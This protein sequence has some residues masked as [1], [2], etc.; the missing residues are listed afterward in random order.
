[1]R[2]I[3][4]SEQGEVFDIAADLG[5]AETRILD[6]LRVAQRAKEAVHLLIRGGEVD[7]VSV[8]GLR[9]S[10]DLVE[11]EAGGSVV[12]SESMGQH[13][14]GPEEGE[15]RVEH[16]DID[17]LTAGAPFACEERRG[18]GLGGGVGTRL[19]GHDISDQVGNRHLGIHLD[20]TVAREALDDRVVDP[21]LAI[22][23]IGAVARDR[24]VDEVGVERAQVRIA[25]AQAIRRAR[26][27][28]LHEDIRVADEPMGGSQAFFPGQV[29][30]DG[31]LVAIAIGVERGEPAPGDGIEA[32]GVSRRNGFE[33]DDVRPLVSQHHRRQG[34]RDHCRCIHHLDPLERSGQPSSSSLSGGS[35]VHRGSGMGERVLAGPGPR[36]RHGRRG[37]CTIQSTHRPPRPA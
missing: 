26:S 35:R 33:F 31:S 28:I 4:F 5:V 13:A 11:G 16:G 10:V 6:P 27:P 21:P 14:V 18:D 32:Q 17:V 24:A 29:E 15:G 20:C 8:F 9:E 2:E 19:I 23:A 36:S 1:M 12:A 3:R 7:Q 30:G 25:E 37:L 22:G 34:S